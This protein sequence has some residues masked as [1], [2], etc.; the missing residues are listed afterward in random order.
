MSLVV[1][2]LKMYISQNYAKELGTE[3][4]SVSKSITKT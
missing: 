2:T 3:V 4:G 1:Q